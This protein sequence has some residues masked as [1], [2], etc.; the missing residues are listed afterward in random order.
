MPIQAP[1]TLEEQRGRFRWLKTAVHVRRFSAC[2]S[3]LPL[4]ATHHSRTNVACYRHN[5]RYC[6]FRVPVR[7][8]FGARLGVQNIRAH[9]LPRRRGRARAS[10]QIWPS[11]ASRGGWQHQRRRLVRA[12]RRGGE[13]HHRRQEVQPDQRQSHCAALAGTSRGN[14]AQRAVTHSHSRLHLA[15]VIV[16]V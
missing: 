2:V 13:E 15:T 7:P 5:V 11:H 10:L 9:G 3:F 1:M 14:C 8:R 12:H 6:Q 16:N 4:S